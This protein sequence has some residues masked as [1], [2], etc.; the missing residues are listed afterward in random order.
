M[1]WTDIYDPSS[2]SIVKHLDNTYLF[3]TRRLDGDAMLA[4][5]NQISSSRCDMAV[6][7]PGSWSPAASWSAAACAGWLLDP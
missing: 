4:S 1:P 7:D 2:N 5:S 3:P 6:I